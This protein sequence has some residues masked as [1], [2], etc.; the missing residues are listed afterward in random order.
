MYYYAAEGLNFLYTASVYLRLKRVKNKRQNSLYKSL[1]I[2]ELQ[3][4]ISKRCLVRLQKGV[5][6]IA[7][8]HLLEANWALI[9][10][11]KSVF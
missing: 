2:K 9:E 3:N 5:S 11:Q 7:K 1:A 6:C 4:S 8:G 10:N